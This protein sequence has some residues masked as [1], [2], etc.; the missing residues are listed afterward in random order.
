[1][2]FDS[3]SLLFT[4]CN[5]FCWS[6][7]L[8]DS[9]FVNYCLWTLLNPKQNLL[10]S[11]TISSN[12]PKIHFAQLFVWTQIY[13]DKQIWKAKKK[14]KDANIVLKYHSECLSNLCKYFLHFFPGLS[15]LIPEVLLEILV[16]CFL[17]SYMQG[18]WTEWS[19]A[20]WF[21][22]AERCFLCHLEK[23]VNSWGLNCVWLGIDYRIVWWWA[24]FSKITTWA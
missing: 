10:C 1:M 24:S 8:S 9:L 16:N 19:S 5:T 23:S 6:Y 21:F 7:F 3:L 2:L 17:N 4:L 20:Q 14:K 18:T 12:R 13:S 11:W 15:Y 22:S